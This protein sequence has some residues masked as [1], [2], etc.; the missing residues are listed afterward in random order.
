MKWTH[1]TATSWMSKWHP[2]L[3]M[4]V[5]VRAVIWIAYLY[6]DSW[7]NSNNRNLSGRESIQVFNL[8]LLTLSCSVHPHQTRGV[9]QKGKTPKPSLDQGHS[10]LRTRWGAASLAL[11]LSVLQRQQQSK[12]LSPV[13]ERSCCSSPRV[14]KKQ[15][16]APHP[17]PRLGTLVWR[18]GRRLCPT[19]P[20][21]SWTRLE[22]NVLSVHSCKIFSLAKEIFQ[23][24]T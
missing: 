21:P 13:W 6:P 22:R 23:L 1:I 5:K 20:A 3:E 12:A 18:A 2:C 19:A 10:G 7:E 4:A 24:D 11:S 9:K 16:K 14:G 8:Q 15:D 17:L